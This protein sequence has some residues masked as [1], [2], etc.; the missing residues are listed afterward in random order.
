MF[1][2]EFSLVLLQPLLFAQLWVEVFGQLLFGFF[3]PNVF[4]LKLLS[5][6]IL[7]VLEL[8]RPRP[9]FLSLHFLFRLFLLHILNNTALFPL[10]LAILIKHELEPLLLLLPILI[11]L[12]LDPMHLLHDTRIFGYLIRLVK[13]I[14][15]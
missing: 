9:F 4:F 3:K 15:P 11:D 2:D 1:C 5:F 13:I 7:K 6:L 14:K 8:L 10:F 12:L